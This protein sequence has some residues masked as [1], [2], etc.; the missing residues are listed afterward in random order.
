MEGDERYTFEFEVPP[1]ENLYVKVTGQ[2]IDHGPT[3]WDS[4]GQVESGYTPGQNWGARPEPYEAEYGRET[5]C[6][7][8][9]CNACRNGLWARWRITRVR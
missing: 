9:F 4:L 5:P 7:D 3:D 6:D 2:E 1:S 8:P